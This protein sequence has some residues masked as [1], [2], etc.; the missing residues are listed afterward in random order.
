MP[1]TIFNWTVIPGFGEP[2]WSECVDYAIRRHG[3]RRWTRIA[4]FS[5][6]TPWADKDNVAFDAM[7]YGAIRATAAG[8]LTLFGQLSRYL[9]CYLMFWAAPV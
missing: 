4:E 2:S 1:S 9:D 3:F 6:G 7:A 8:H 5:N